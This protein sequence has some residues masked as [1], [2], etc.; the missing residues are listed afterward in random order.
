MKAN[1]R[2]FVYLQL[3]VDGWWEEV[4]V[5][6]F[7]TS[8]WG[9]KRSELQT[10]LTLLDR[11]KILM[12]KTY[13]TSRV[14]FDKKISELVIMVLEDAG[15]DASEYIVDDTGV[16]SV[17]PYAWFEPITHW[18]A[19]CKLAEAEGGHVYINEYDRVIFECHEHLT[20]GSSVVTL[21]YDKHF[22]DATD[23]WD[24]GLMRN[25]IIVKSEPL[26]LREPVQEEVWKLDHKVVVPSMGTLDV[27]AT[28]TE[29]TSIVQPVLDASVDTRVTA[30]WKTP[31]SSTS[32][33]ITLTNNG[34]GAETVKTGELMVLA[35]P[36][37][38][39]VWELGEDTLVPAYSSIEFEAL[40]DTV[41]CI[42]IADPVVTHD[43]VTVEWKNVPYAFG[44]VIVIENTTAEDITLESAEVLVRAKPLERVGVIKKERKDDDSILDHGR[45]DAT[46]ENEFLQNDVLATS[47]AEYLLAI[48]KDPEG[49][50][51]LEQEV[52]GMPHLQL[53]DKV[54]LYDPVKL[55]LNTVYWITG[56]ELTWDGSLGGNLELIPDIGGG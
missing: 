26:R 30:V 29:S 38:Y 48:Y 36:V 2:T 21:E 37:R 14:V 13:A 10:R 31:P 25:D 18:N 24:E 9:S 44:G 51:K 52:R 28:Y 35:K 53:A 43:G 4:P 23:D 16:D 54:T 45:R 46:F 47:L 22:S 7:Y 42:D 34:Y 41:P 39:I 1:Q 50:I 27:P 6:V 20:G 49:P 12:E 3:F 15:L 55:H 17:I 33:T 56:M 40:F 32:G 8:K 11:S 5:G 19:L